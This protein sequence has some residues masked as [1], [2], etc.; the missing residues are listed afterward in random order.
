M[1][2]VMQVVAT[3]GRSSAACRLTLLILIARYLGR[4]RNR[5][6]ALAA[7]VACRDGAGAAHPRAA[8]GCRRMTRRR[9]RRRD[10]PGCCRGS[11]AGWCIWA[12][13]TRRATAASCHHMLRDPEFQELLR[14][15]PQM[16]RL[17]RPLFWALNQTPS[18]RS[19]A[20]TGRAG[21][22]RRLATTAPQHRRGGDRCSHG[23]GIPGQ[24]SCQPS[25][26]PGGQQ[27]CGAR[28][29]PGGISAQQRPARID[30]A[31]LLPV[32]IGVIIFR[33]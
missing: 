25:C 6:A 8:R 28:P 17:L 4:L 32:P 23:R 15:A 2:R 16:G 21:A 7:R 33:D 12:A 19:A 11:S 5:F 14:A 18:P 30:W 29:P 27:S 10:R 31:S 13:T 9:R 3:V 1:S 26:Q 24:P 22:T 20:A